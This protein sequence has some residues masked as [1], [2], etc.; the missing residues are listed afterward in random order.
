MENKCLGHIISDHFLPHKMRPI[1]ATLWGEFLECN[2]PFVTGVH[3]TNRWCTPKNVYRVELRIYGV[4]LIIYGLI[5]QFIS[6]QNIFSNI[7]TL[8]GSCKN[9]TRSLEKIKCV[10]CTD[11]SSY[12]VYFISL[13]PIDIG[14]S[15]CPYYIYIMSCWSVWTLIMGSS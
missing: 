15:K 5:L 11:A 12:K 1:S 9:W 13:H 10:N 8:Y 4:Q 2:P 14:H 3:P 6:V 7:F